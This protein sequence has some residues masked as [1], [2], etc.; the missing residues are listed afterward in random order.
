MLA[1]G[2]AD[3]YVPQM[4]EW[5]DI[6]RF[7]FHHWMLLAIPLLMVLLGHHK[8]SYK[9][10]LNAPTGLLLVML[11]IM[12]NQL[13]QAELG[14]IPMRNQD[15][16]DINYKNTSYIWQPDG[17]IGNFLATFCPDFMT[18]VPVG[19][20]AGQTKYWPLFWL[21]VPAFVLVTPIAFGIFMIFDHKSFV[22]DCKTVIGKIKAIPERIRR[23]K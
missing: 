12:L 5:I 3:V 10:A 14:F 19:E 22:C 4:E 8:I 6:V 13:F 17:D 9:R 23:R 1:N 2:W 7:Y 15:F 20:Y 11:F 21:L 18:K 16:L